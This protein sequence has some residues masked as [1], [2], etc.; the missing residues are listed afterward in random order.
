MNRTI[1]VLI[2]ISCLFAAGNAQ[3]IDNKR[4]LDKMYNDIL[5]SIPAS[6]R[7]LIDSTYTSSQK[8]QINGNNT[9]FLTNEND[10][11]SAGNA[12]DIK[13][14]E[15]VNRDLVKMMQQIDTM[16]QKRMI[17]FKSTNVP[18]E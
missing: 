5:K 17:H 7:A 14:P 6:Q 13:L 3:S 15:A 8:K 11:A 2:C 16:R 10:Q 1:A 12:E 18:T 9:T 4:V